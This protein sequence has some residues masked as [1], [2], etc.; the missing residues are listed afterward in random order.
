MGE[1]KDLN[2]LLSEFKSNLEK[3]IDLEKVILFGSRA[4]EE[5]HEDSDVDLIIVSKNFR[6]RDYFERASM[7]YDYW[8][9]ELPVDFL[10]YTPEEFEKLE[11]QASIVR[12][13][14]RTGIEA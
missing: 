14:T 6:G 5:A 8:D 2:S 3:D 11:N 9:S 13:A 1:R 4:V 10:C 7:M 12:E